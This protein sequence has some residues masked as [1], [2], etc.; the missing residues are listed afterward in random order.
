VTP[1]S[2]QQGRNWWFPEDSFCPISFQG[3]S[4]GILKQDEMRGK[5]MLLERGLEPDVEQWSMLVL[6][7]MLVL[8]C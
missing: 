7:Q 4:E 3:I 5:K 2:S 1:W 6:P 8:S